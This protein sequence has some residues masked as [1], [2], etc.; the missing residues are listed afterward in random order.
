MANYI[1]QITSEGTAQCLVM[2][3]K[4][5]FYSK[6]DALVGIYRDK[7]KGCSQSATLDLSAWDVQEQASSVGGA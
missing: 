1:A 3:L 7:A 6:A 5:L 4:D 2:S